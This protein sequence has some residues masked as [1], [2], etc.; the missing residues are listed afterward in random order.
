MI[1]RLEIGQAIQL[2]AN[3]GVIAGIVFLAVEINQNTEMMEAQMSQARTEAAMAEAQSLYN[4]EYVLPLLESIDQGQ[5]LSNVDRQ[6]FM[7]YLRAFNRNQDNQL[8][9]YGQGLLGENIPRSIR[10]AVRT[11]IAARP[12]ARE[13]W[14]STKD[15]Y[16][17]EYIEMVDKIVAEIPAEEPGN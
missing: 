11:E 16:T 2:L 5:P 17:D 7:H 13:I 15:I 6:R 10:R 8:W 12:L 9:L 3:L 14:A 4:S 1:K